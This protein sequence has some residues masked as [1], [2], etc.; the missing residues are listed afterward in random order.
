MS[1]P[2]S[3]INS[4]SSR[5]WWEPRKLLGF[6]FEKK[7]NQCP[8]SPKYCIFNTLSRILLSLQEDR[9]PGLSNPNNPLLTLGF[10]EQIRAA[11]NICTVPFGDP[12]MSDFLNYFINLVPSCNLWVTVS[13]KKFVHL[14]QDVEFDIACTYCT[15]AGPSEGG[16][17]VSP[18]LA[19]EMFRTGPR[20]RKLVWEEK[21]G[22]ESNVLA[23]WK[24][25]KELWCQ[26]SSQGAGSCLMPAIL[27]SPL[28]LFSGLIWDL[29]HPAWWW[30]DKAVIYLSNF[31]LPQNKPSACADPFHAAQGELNSGLQSLQFFT[32]PHLV[33][34]HAFTYSSGLRPFFF[35][36]KSCGRYPQEA[37][38]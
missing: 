37:G 9:N 26:P 25:I 36:P 6:F 19:T 16:G 4:Y 28:R 2:F 5:R 24:Q 27:P 33:S 32:S 14:A 23:I 11:L 3:W 10:L 22:V 15:R 21:G 38:S 12:G 35:H 8:Q 17:A 20:A 34:L 7:I 18:A 1:C 30:G 29:E 31:I 13:L